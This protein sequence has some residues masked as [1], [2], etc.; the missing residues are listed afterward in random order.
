MTKWQLAVRSEV[1]GSKKTVTTQSNHNHKNIFI[2]RY[3]YQLMVQFC[4][5]QVVECRLLANQLHFQHSLF[6]ITAISTHSRWTFFLDFS[7]YRSICFGPE[8]SFSSQLEKFSCS[9][10]LM[11]W[12]KLQLQM[13]SNIYIE[14]IHVRANSIT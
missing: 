7:T 9:I 6:S 13:D 5:W 10:I 11:H 8:V 12:L 1:T 2:Y 14:D 4:Y 3:V